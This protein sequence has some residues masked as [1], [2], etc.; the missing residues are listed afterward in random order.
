VVSSSIAVV[1]FLSVLAFALPRARAGEAAS[2]S[3]SAS[4]ERSAAELLDA[5]FAN[6][7]DVDLTSNIELLVSDKSGA[8]QRRL[9][10]AAQKIIGDKVHSIGRLEF[11]EY[12]R[13]MTV[14]TVE[15]IDRGHDAFLYMPSQGRVR[16]VSTAQKGDAFFGTDVTYEDL[17]RHSA[18]SYELG[19]MTREE[20]NGVPVI[21]IPAKPKRPQNYERVIFV[22][23]ADEDVMLEHHF[24]KR[25]SET[26]WRIIYSPRDKMQVLSGHLLPTYLYVDNLERKTRTEVWLRDLR[27]DVELSDKV[28]SVKNLE[29]KGPIPGT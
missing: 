11:P 6:R 23:S 2:A 24:F 26:P 3:A 20:R 5:A 15:A 1:A 7:Y 14:L 17:E 12:L 16:R 13:G 18:A 19:E 22:L 25:R 9:V 28:F 27:V 8:T 21:A 10:R 4:R 29:A